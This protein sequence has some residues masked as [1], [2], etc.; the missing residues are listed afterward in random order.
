MSSISTGNPGVGVWTR[1]ARAEARQP[2]RREVLR[3]LLAG[4][5]AGSLPGC[6]A[7]SNAVTDARVTPPELADRYVRLTRELARHQPSLVEAWLGAT[8]AAARPRRPV[9]AI[10]AETTALAADLETVTRLIAAAD[11]AVGAGARGVAS[12]RGTAG[13]AAI[14]DAM[15]LRYLLGQARALD[16]AAARLLGE[17]LS[18]A[19]EARR[20]FG[21]VAPPR[22][23]ATL[24]AVR[25]ELGALLPG[26]GSGTLA[27]RHREFRRRH[28][29]PA[30]RVEAVFR[31]AVDW[32]RAAARQHL[33]LPEGETL[34]TRAEDTEGWA[35][36][37]R[38]TGLLSSDLWVARR[39]GA[40]AA[41]LLQLAAH[42]GTPGHH[43]Q[44]VLASAALVRDRGWTERLLH[45]SFGPHRLFAEGAAEASADLLLPLDV[46]VQVCR[47]VL[48]PA[49]GQSP[50]V[51]AT[52]VRVE[53]LAAS[54]D[55][56]VAYIAE[57]YLDSP[58]GSEAATAR[59]RD[60]ALVL[61][62]PGMLAF[63]ERQRSKMLA[64][65]VGRRLVRDAV[66]GATGAG[67]RWARLARI[68]TTLGLEG[69]AGE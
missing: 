3:A 40:D 59:L 46:R 15:R 39:G 58:L 66:D 69:A 63:L 60:E 21:H 44:H 26:S 67:A 47:D 32:C 9:A 34:T 28:A 14:T 30:D 41:H 27:E 37:S 55:L 7:V 33:A 49:A 57:D 18:F 23:A 62:P 17:S 31:A 43:A 42:E 65:P 61:D 64:Y 22:D 53:R 29:V 11:G 1:A 35:A 50:A 13:P 20:T 52:L 8:D 68:S 48:L 56:E 25:S 16:T 6:E 4:A 45:P 19:D 38:P 51:A 54:L 2:G 24:A 12:A 36:F 5:L 10:R